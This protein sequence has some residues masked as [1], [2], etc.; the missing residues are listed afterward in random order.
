ML[1]TL[2]FKFKYLINYYVQE[3]AK[4]TQI[5]SNSYDDILLMDVFNAEVSETI[6]I[7]NEKVVWKQRPS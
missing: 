7:R 3:L 5:Y 6:V 4:G 2:R 1:K